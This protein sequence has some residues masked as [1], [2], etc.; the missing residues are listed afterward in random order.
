MPCPI[1]TCPC[2]KSLSSSLLGPLQV[3]KDCSKVSQEP[4][5]LQ[6]E[7]P[8][9]PQPFLIGDMFHPSDNFCG[10]ALDLFQ[11]V[12]VCP[13]LRAPE[14]DAGLPLGSHQSRVEGQNRLPWPAG[15]AAFAIRLVEFHEVHTGPPLKPVKAPLDGIPSL[16][17]VNC[18]TIGLCFIS[19]NMIKHPMT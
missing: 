16:Q 13:V 12:H 3:L 19:N 7:Q 6:A 4:S 9:L 11:Q 15:H 8:Q 2:K 1:T 18:T 14:L 10:P 17:R 5:L